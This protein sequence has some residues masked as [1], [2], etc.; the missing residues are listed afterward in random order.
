MQKSE[1]QLLMQKKKEHHERLEKIRN[2]QV[3]IW[4]NFFLS[5]NFIS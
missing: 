3:S 4:E 5:T 1:K 2:F